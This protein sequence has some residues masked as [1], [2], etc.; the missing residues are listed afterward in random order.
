MSNSLDLDPSG[1]VFCKTM[2][3]VPVLMNFWRHK[4]TRLALIV[5]LVTTATSAWLIP[6]APRRSLPARIAGS[7]PSAAFSPDFRYAAFVSSEYRDE[8]KDRD[9][10]CTIWDVP[11]GRALFS[12]PTPKRPYMADNYALRIS[13]DNAFVVELHQGQPRFWKMPSGEPWSPELVANIPH[14]LFGGGVSHLE[15]DREGRPLIVVREVWKSRVRDLVSG[16]ELATLPPEGVWCDFFPG[17]FV[18]HLWEEEKIE[19]RELPSG[20]LRRELGLRDCDFVRRGPWVRY[21]WALTPDLNT[22]ALVVEDKIYSWDVRTGARRQLDVPSEQL[23]TSGRSVSFQHVALS[24]DGRFFIFRV[25]HP[26]NPKYAWLEHLLDWIGWPPR[27]AE[28]ALYDLTANTEIVSFRLPS[29]PQGFSSGH[30]K[31][32]LDGKSLAIVHEDGV[33]I[34]DFPVRRPWPK[35]AACALVASGIVWVLGWLV[36]LRAARP[37]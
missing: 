8:E 36:G 16:K 26:P 20:T 1:T 25:D 28:L 2:P 34:Y 11:S 15:T 22:V 21:H 32:S 5:G 35:I 4:A 14:D 31:F 23:P 19:I 13:P 27:R 24:P 29:N 12:F 10:K 33:D 37:R 30:A 6:Y 7:R 18:R 17:G 9:E 3:L